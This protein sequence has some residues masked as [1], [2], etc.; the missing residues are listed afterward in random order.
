MNFS[1]LHQEASCKEEDEDKR[2]SSSRLMNLRSRTRGEALKSEDTADT[3]NLVNA[4]IKVEAEGYSVTIG[5]CIFDDFH[6]DPQL[7]HLAG[8]SESLP[9]DSIKHM[10][11]PRV[12]QVQTKPVQDRI[13]AR[14]SKQ[15]SSSRSAKPYRLKKPLSCPFCPKSFYRR[16]HLQVHLRTHTGEKP[17]GC[18]VC[19]KNF[20]HSSNLNAHQRI[21]TREK[22]YHCTLCGKMFSSLACFKGHMTL[23]GQN[24][25]T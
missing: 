16:Y 19:G 25:L 1:D 7:Y 13:Q 12:K 5:E 15:N 20:A 10:V 6:N 14:T 22:P 3:G 24:G 8:T 9:S 18:A 2:M 23:H 17:F 11:E 21:H 4:A